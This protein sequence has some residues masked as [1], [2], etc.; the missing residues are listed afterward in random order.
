MF[1]LLLQVKRN[2]QIFYPKT[3]YF[4]QFYTYAI[5]YA[6]YLAPFCYILTLIKHNPCKF[7]AQ[8]VFFY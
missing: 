6:K 5:R 8:I 2:S 7:V 4:R 1:D 3:L